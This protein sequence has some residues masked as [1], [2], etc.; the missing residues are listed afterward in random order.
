LGIR[1]N[2][3]QP[4]LLLAEGF[5]LPRLGIRTNPAQPGL[6]LAEGFSLPRLGIRTNLAQPGLLL[7]DGCCKGSNI[8]RNGIEKV[9]KSAEKG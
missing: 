7:A 2:P 8:S 5:S 3:A 1:T 9:G 4:G 6:L